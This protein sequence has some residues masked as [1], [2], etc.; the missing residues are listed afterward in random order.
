MGGGE[1]AGLVGEG[2]AREACRGV[3][4]LEMNE[5]ASSLMKLRR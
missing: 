4:L 1:N 5:A 3:P 2:S